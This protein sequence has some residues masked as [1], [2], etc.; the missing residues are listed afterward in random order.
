MIGSWEVEAVLHDV[1]GR[2]QKSK[3]EVHAAWVLEG[4]AI[5]DLFIYPRRADRQS[6]RPAQGDRYGTTIKTY[7]PKYL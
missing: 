4:R 6:G 3:G 5:Q 1:S 2:M 7:D